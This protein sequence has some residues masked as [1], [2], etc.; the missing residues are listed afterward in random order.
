MNAADA[1][2]KEIVTVNSEANVLE[3]AR[4]M[5]QHR[6]SGLPVVDAGGKLVGMLTEGDLLHRAETGTERRRSRWLEMLVGPGRVADEYTHAHARKVGE[7]MTT[8]VVSVTPDTPLEK[9]VETM[10]HRKI[11]RVAVVQGGRMVG[12][13][14]RS[15][16]LHGL[17]AAS[18]KPAA[19]ASVPGTDAAIRDAILA[20]FS[21]QPWAPRAVIKVEVRNGV[22][23]VGGTITDERERMALKVATENVPGVKS[24]ID[25]LVWVE[26]ISG[27]VVE[28]P[29]NDRK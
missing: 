20:E 28:P 29:D 13:V 7:I 5:L 12:L 27:M 24:V 18:V 8:P 22:A 19:T 15:D 3:A 21:R 17:I 2:T 14:S 4:L 25:H 23:T 1:M 6:V 9:V 11:K 16:L 26:P 10:E